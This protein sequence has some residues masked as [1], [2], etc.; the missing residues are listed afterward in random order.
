[1]GINVSNRVLLPLHKADEQSYCYSFSHRSATKVVSLNTRFPRIYVLA[2]IPGQ[3][4][5]IFTRT[6][7]AF[8]SPTG[9]IISSIRLDYRDKDKNKVA[10][11]FFGTVKLTFAVITTPIFIA[12]QLIIEI[13]HLFKV[14]MLIP[15]GLINPTDGGIFYKHSGLDQSE[16]RKSTREVSRKSVFPHEKLEEVKKIEP[17]LQ[18]KVP[19]SPSPTKAKVINIQTNKTPLLYKQ[20]IK[21]LLNDLMD[22]NLAQ[23]TG[24]HALFVDEEKH[25]T[26]A[27]ANQVK[28][29]MP[30]DSDILGSEETSYIEQL[31]TPNYQQYFT[32]FADEFL[33]KLFEKLSE[34]HIGKTNSTLRH[35]EFV[36]I[37]NQVYKILEEFGK[38][39]KACNRNL[40]F[41]RIVNEV[42]NKYQF[43]EPHLKPLVDAT[44]KSKADIT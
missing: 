13:G 19:E 12:L 2:M 11:V 4:V 34:V 23:L 9:I 10:T 41:V 21:R 8:V 1:M 40:E 22:G 16:P 18:S 14:F 27:R 33:K 37:K 15:F 38:I 35:G 24:I 6:A 20:F 39:A 7:R 29:L 5:D 43:L 3:I 31:N 28:K 36:T 17:K 30:I 26:F 32:Y 25:F 44:N 42:N